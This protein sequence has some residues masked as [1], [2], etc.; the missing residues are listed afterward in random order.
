MLRNH[1]MATCD[2]SVILRY[3]LSKNGLGMG[4]RAGS[5]RARPLKGAFELSSRGYLEIPSSQ[6]MSGHVDA[7]TIYISLSVA[8]YTVSVV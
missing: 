4:T 1:R 7:S 2:G 6:G 3:A 8:W 5:A